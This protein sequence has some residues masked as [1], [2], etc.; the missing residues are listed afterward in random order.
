MNRDSTEIVLFDFDEPTE[1]E[2]W[3]PINDTVMGGVSEST[4]EVGGPSTAVFAG[5]V[6]LENY[7]GFASVRSPVRDYDLRRY[8]GLRVRMKGDGKRYSLSLRADVA[9]DG[10]AYQAGLPTQAEAWTEVDVDFKELAPTFHGRVLQNTPG[11]DRRTIKSFSLLIADRQEGP[12]RLEIDWIKAYRRS[13]RG[14][15]AK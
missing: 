1:L 10:V 7:G 4:F 2:E 11:I 6:S 9:F 13:A 3:Q 8:D 14:S 15:P 12:F 5:T